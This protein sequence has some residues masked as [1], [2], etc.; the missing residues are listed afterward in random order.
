MKAFLNDLKIAVHVPWRGIDVC[1][2]PLSLIGLILKVSLN[3]CKITTSRGK[4]PL[5]EELLF[6][7]ANCWLSESGGH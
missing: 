7:I 4:F 6:G 5:E 1:G 3:Q 2:Q